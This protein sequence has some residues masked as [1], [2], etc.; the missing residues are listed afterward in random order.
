MVSKNRGTY[1]F[2]GTLWV[3]ITMAPRNTDSCICFQVE[4]NMAWQVQCGRRPIDTAVFYRPPCH[5]WKFLVCFF[6]CDGG[7]KT[8]LG[9]LSFLL[10]HGNSTL[11]KEDSDKPVTKAMTFTLKSGDELQIDIGRERFHAPEIIFQVSLA[12]FFFVYITY[13]H[14][15]RYT[16]MLSLVIALYVCE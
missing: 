10:V 5:T 1:G 8:V 4:I 12:V 7:L 16:Y 14:V 6:F 13:I 9:T 2:L 15:Y 3:L 11:D